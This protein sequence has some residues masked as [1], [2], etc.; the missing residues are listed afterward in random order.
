MNPE[1][2]IDWTAIPDSK[3]YRPEN[4]PKAITGIRNCDPTAPDILYQVANN[5][6]G[7][8]YPAAVIATPILLD[9]A[10]HSYNHKAAIHALSAL[11]TL[12]WFRG[13]PPFQTLVYEDVEI[14][15][16]KAIR[17]QVE[18]SRAKLMT[19]A[20]REPRLRK[21]V[22]VLLESVDQQPAE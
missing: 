9:I 8:L 20:N 17:Q 6:S 15:L 3:W 2:S 12:V 5:H 7:E 11:D 21:I 16:D 18:T 1:E 4:V 13:E 22:Y 10:F 14:T 19:L